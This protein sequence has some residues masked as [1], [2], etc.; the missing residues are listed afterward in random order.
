[1]ALARGAR[2][3]PDDW[4]A[5]LLAARRGAGPRGVRAVSQAEAHKARR[6]GVDRVELRAG[7]GEVHQRAAGRVSVVA[8]MER[9]DIRDILPA[10]RFAQCGLRVTAPSAPLCIPSEAPPWSCR[11]PAVQPATVPDG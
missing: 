3:L 6:R 7:A 9:S 5:R 8:R 2:V 1:R 11:A 10:F 4:A